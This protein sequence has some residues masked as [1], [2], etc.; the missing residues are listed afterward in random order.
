M[1]TFPGG[2]EVKPRNIEEALRLGAAD[3]RDVDRISAR[4]RHRWVNFLRL[5]I[6]PAEKA[7]RFSMISIFVSFDVGHFRPS[8][9][10]I[11]L[12][13]VRISGET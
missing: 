9:V 2:T 11:R 3:L 13:R 10:E 6:P 5:A 12:G 1:V 8:G 4:R 7:F